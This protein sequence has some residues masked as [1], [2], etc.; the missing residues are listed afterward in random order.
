MAVNLALSGLRQNNKLM[1]HIAAN[2]SSFGTHR[3]CLQSHASECP[4]IGDKHFIISNPARIRI[5]VKGICILH[6]EFPTTHDP[7]ARPN[8]IPK[9]P[10]NMIKVQWKVSVAAN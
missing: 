7:K 6:I 2:W 8:F 3:D 4:K 1:A 9:F 10:L 5:E